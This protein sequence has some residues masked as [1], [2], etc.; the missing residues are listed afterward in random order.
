[1]ENIISEFDILDKRGIMTYRHSTTNILVY[2]EDGTKYVEYLKTAPLISFDKIHTDYLA[3]DYFI[4]CPMN[5]EVEV[6]VVEKLCNMGKTVFVDLG[7]YGGATSDIRHSIY[8]DYGREVIGR[9]CRSGSI[10]KASKEDLESIIPGKTPEEAADY[11]T[12]E[13]ASS[14]VV[15]LGGD[16]AM[17]RVGNGPLTYMD[18]SDA[19]SENPDGKFDF[20]GAGDSFGAGF[21]VSF[22]KNRDIR[23]AV[24]NGNATAS[25]VI[26]RSGGCTLDR[27]PTKEKVEQRIKSKSVCKIG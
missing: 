16:G 26:Q 3:S 8:T 5:Y 18:P 25:L 19:F 1:M 12:Q 11:L 6:E 9:L 13:G 23:A 15:T 10:I 4:I 7:G 22:T 21:M 17:F 27:M 2:R 20:T 24:E 14:V